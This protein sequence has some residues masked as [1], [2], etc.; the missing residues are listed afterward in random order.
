MTVGRTIT[1]EDWLGIIEEHSVQFLVLDPHTDSALVGL[2]RS[3]P[4]WTVD[5]EDEEAVLFARTDAVQTHAS[6][7]NAA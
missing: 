1:N 4:R 2:F 7:R 6:A 3:Q 5:F